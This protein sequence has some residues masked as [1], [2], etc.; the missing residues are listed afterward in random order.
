MG[1]NLNNYFANKRGL[2]HTSNYWHGPELEA[3][4]CLAKTACFL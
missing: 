4:A 1:Q 3:G 2:I